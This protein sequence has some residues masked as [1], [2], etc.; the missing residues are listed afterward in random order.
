[1][2]IEKLTNDAC[3]GSLLYGAIMEALHIQGATLTGWCRDRHINELMVKRAIYGLD[4]GWQEKRLLKDLI[5]NVGAQVVWDEYVS[6]LGIL[7]QTMNEG[8]AA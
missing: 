3:C 8:G 5:E 6:Q 4:R 7:Y 1:M 2:D